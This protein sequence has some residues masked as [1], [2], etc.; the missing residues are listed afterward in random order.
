MA[1]WI[2]IALL[3]P[4]VIFSVRSRPLPRLIDL[5]DVSITQE[6]IA[7]GRYSACLKLIY[8]RE[9]PY[10]ELICACRFVFSYRT[11]YYDRGERWIKREEHMVDDALYPFGAS[12]LYLPFRLFHTARAVHRWKTE[13]G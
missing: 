9:N 13:A 10:L 5:S 12:I 7:E 8:R 6:Y 1:D 11:F 4:V 3:T 2:G